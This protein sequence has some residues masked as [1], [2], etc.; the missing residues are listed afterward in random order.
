MR[1]YWRT[2]GSS[3]EIPIATLSYFQAFDPAEA[4]IPKTNR[5]CQCG[6][7]LDII[8][9]EQAANEMSKQCLRSSSQRTAADV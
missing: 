2:S 6:L 3:L 7:E 4:I 1:L 5:I 8:Y 9:S